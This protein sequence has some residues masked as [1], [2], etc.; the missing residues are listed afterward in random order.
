MKCEYNG[1]CNR[2]VCQQPNATW[3]NHSTLKYY[4]ESCANLINNHNHDESIELF[5]HELCTEGKH[6]DC[7]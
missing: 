6:E 4:C 7:D 1:N 3:Y 5:G 2:T